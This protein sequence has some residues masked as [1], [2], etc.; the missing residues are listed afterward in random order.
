MNYGELKTLVNQYLEV[1]ETTFNDNIDV[2]VRA[3][4]EDIFRQVQLPDL[5][6][7]STANFIA[8][9]QFLPVPSNFLSP[10]SLAVV[11]N[12][13]YEMMLSKDH[14]FIRETYPGVSQQGVPRFYAVYNDANFLIGPVP[15]D[16]YVVELNYFYEPPSLTAGSD[17]GTTWLSINAEN[18][19]LFGTLI[20]GYTYLKG[21]Q[22]VAKQYVE[23]YQT[24]LAALKVLAE[25][26]NRKDVYR[27]SDRRIAT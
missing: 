26:R 11:V 4:E 20:Q 2:F 9:N 7:T 24:A 21:D 18:A 12:G 3:A 15:D 1:N 5:M 8:G 17:S 19:I 22:D 13:Q 16:D 6:Q 25:G 23:Q 10:Y 27:T 14:S